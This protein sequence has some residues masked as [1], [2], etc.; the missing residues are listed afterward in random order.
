MPDGAAAVERYRSRR[1]SGE[2]HVAVIMDLTVRGGLGGKEVVQRLL[3]VDPEVKAV[4]SSGYSAD[5]VLASCRDD[6]FSA[7]LAKPYSR[8]DLGRMPQELLA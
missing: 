7:V 4:V 1:E 3:L 2:P 8:Q 6:G 5:P